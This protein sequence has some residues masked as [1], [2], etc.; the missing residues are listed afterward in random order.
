MLGLKKKQGGSQNDLKKVLGDFELPTIPA[1]VTA[2][3]DKIASPDCDMAEVGEVVATDTRRNCETT[4]P[5]V[6]ATVDW[7]HEIG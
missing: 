2:A 5:V 6:T 7:G 3:I 1:V 4:D